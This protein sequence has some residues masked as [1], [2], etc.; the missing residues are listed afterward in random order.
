[1]MQPVEIHIY[2]NRVDLGLEMSPNN[3]KYWDIMDPYTSRGRHRI[4]LCIF[5]PE[6]G[7]PKCVTPYLPKVLPVK[8]RGGV[9]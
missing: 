1:M 5:C 6:G 7:T 2:V 3:L 4:L 9:P 8:G